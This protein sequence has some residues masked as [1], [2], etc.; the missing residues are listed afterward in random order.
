MNDSTALSLQSSEETVQ[1]VESGSLS[2]ENLN[3]PENSIVIKQDGKLIVRKKLS[4]DERSNPNTKYGCVLGYIIYGR[5]VPKEEYSQKINFEHSPKV[6]YAAIMLALLCTLQ[7]FF[8]LATKFPLKMAKQIYVLAIILF[9]YKNPPQRDIKRHYEESYL[10][11]VFPNTPLSKNKIS[12]LYK[13]IAMRIDA[14]KEY[15]E[16]VLAAIQGGGILYNDGTAVHYSSNNC[17]LSKTGFK[18]KDPKDRVVNIINTFAPDVDEM[19]SSVHP[20]SY[21]DI[22][23]YKAHLTACGLY[24]GIVFGDSAFAASTVEQL[25]SED[26]RFSELSYIGLLKSNDT[27]I[28]DNNLIEYK[29][30]FNSPRGEVLY[31]KKYDEKSGKY[32]Y[33]FKNLDIASKNE[34]NFSKTHRDDPNFDDIYNNKR[35]KFGVIILESPIDF[36][37]EVLYDIVIHRWTIETLFFQEKNFLNFDCIRVQGYREVIGQDFVRSISTSIFLKVRSYVKSLGLLANSTFSNIIERLK[38]VWR[39]ISDVEREKVKND[40]QWAIKDEGKPIT[41]DDSWSYLLKK[42]MSLLETLKISKPDPNVNNDVKNQ[43]DDDAKTKTMSKKNNKKNQNIFDILNQKMEELSNIVTNITD[44]VLKKWSSTLAKENKAET[45]DDHPAEKKSRGRHPGTLNKKTYQCIGL[46]KKICE[47]LKNIRKEMAAL[48]G[49]IK[50]LSELLAPRKKDSDNEQNKNSGEISIKNDSVRKESDQVQTKDSEDNSVKS[51]S[52][53]Q[54]LTDSNIDDLKNSKVGNDKANDDSRE[55]SSDQGG[56]HQDPKD[57]KNP[58][59]S[60]KGASKQSKDEGEA[61]S[62]IEAASADS[63]AGTNQ[64]SA[65]DKA[66]GKPRRSDYGGRHE[67]PKKRKSRKKLVKEASQQSKDEGEANSLLKYACG[68]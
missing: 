40:I 48:N 29:G 26:P 19:L 63:G 58:K 51:D 34:K 62:L 2:L 30:S 64:P 24:N 35:D 43:K 22:S 45:L 15:N 67:Y 12:E 46:V 47:S 50:E 10:S 32:Y 18:S 55:V 27:R 20:G 33:T 60:V 36:A 66:N 37:P 7:T 41:G 42:D 39:S 3:L 28:K 31:G 1:N 8:L 65:E 11:V 53:T 38:S 56:T 25:K 14:C 9:L 16:A 21:S 54:T 23:V 68:D 59:K 61:N 52:D 57:Q 13:S 49:Y 17:F 4:K 5:Y 6:S 44:T